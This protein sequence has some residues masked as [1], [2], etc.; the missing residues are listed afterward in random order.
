[1]LA[2]DSRTGLILKETATAPLLVRQELALLDCFGGQEGFQPAALGQLGDW[3]QFHASRKRS[4]QFFRLYTESVTPASKNF[5]GTHTDYE[6]RRDS[7]RGLARP[8]TSSRGA[9]HDQRSGSE[10][11]AQR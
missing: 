11:R 6:R 8:C 9:G 10:P 7:S 2:F 4:R 3:P 1:M 5:D